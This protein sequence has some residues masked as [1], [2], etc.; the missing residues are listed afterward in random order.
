M[1]QI[2][3]AYREFRDNFDIFSFT[4]KYYEIQNELNNAIESNSFNQFMQKL[5]DKNDYL[6]MFIANGVYSNLKKMNT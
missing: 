4:E 5:N 6:G 2:E 3:Y 1:K